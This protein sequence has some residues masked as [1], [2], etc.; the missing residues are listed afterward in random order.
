M[1]GSLHR[2]LFL[3]FLSGLTAQWALD[4]VL[5][6]GALCERGIGEYAPIFHPA[7][8]N[9]SGIVITST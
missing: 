2:A 9:H 7:W 3:R 1:I 8:K 5:C 4:F 6:L